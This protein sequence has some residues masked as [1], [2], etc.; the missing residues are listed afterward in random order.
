MPHPD[1]AAVAAVADLDRVLADTDILVLACPLTPATT[2][3][4]DRR[5]L[6]LLP[7]GAGVANIGRG[8]LLDQDALCDALDNGG[9]GGA[10]LDVCDPEPLPIGHRLWRTHNVIIT[11]HIS[12]DDPASYNALSLDIVFANLRAWRAGAVPPNRVDLVRGY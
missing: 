5:R 6:G 4:L 9:L 10:V 8:R 1:F 3:L 11:P 2:G 7:A 12:C